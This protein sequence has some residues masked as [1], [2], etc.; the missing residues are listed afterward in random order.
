M[1]LEDISAHTEGFI[2]I[3]FLGRTV[4]VCNIVFMDLLSTVYI[5]VDGVESIHHHL[6]SNL[7]V[8]Y[9]GFVLHSQDLGH[10]LLVLPGFSLIIFLTLGVTLLV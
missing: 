3:P 8:I 5:V 9:I 6:L 10:L 2:V 7:L 1:L 4:R